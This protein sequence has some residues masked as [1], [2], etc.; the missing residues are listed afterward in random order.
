MAERSDTI[1][2]L[3]LYIDLM[4][5][6]PRA[7]SRITSTELRVSLQEKYPEL[8]RRK[9]DR[10]LKD[11]FE[12]NFLWRDDR[13]KPYGYS[14]PTDNP[15]LAAPQMDHYE[16]LF[17]MFA[18]KHLAN[19]LPGQVS[20]SLA[21]F[22][23]H[24]RD[25]LH[26]SLR[27]S[28]ARDWLDKVEIVSPTMDFIPPHLDSKILNTVTSCLYADK[29]LKVRYRNTEGEIKDHTLIPLGLVQQTPFLYLV[30][31]YE[32]NT[33]KAYTF[34]MHR[35]QSVEASTL[36]SKRAK[37]DLHQYCREDR[38][39]FGTGEQVV[40]DFYVTRYVGRQL[41]ESPLSEDQ[42]IEKIRDEYHIRATVYDSLKLDFFIASLRDEIRDV[43]KIPV[44]SEEESA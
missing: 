29:L 28:I 34:A 18:Q 26:I 41:E 36:P 24:A 9:V 13:T 40:V 21:P 32:G 30:A 8:D 31:H 5:R 19:V 1:T 35:M 42:Q 27:D 4:R 25:Q 14:W 20:S 15:V 16:S 37:F 22:F 17:F 43:K 10:A 39:M 44:K 6:V 12:N 11:L 23:S 3:R 2:L 33:E 7:P 38:H